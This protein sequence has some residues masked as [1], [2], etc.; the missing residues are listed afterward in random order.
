MRVRRRF[1]FG[2]VIAA[3]LAATASG[4]TISTWNGG[5]GNWST[6]ADWTPPVVPNNSGSN[7]YDVT[8]G[9]GFVGLDVS[10]TVNSLTLGASGE[11]YGVGPTVNTIH[12]VND[13]NVNGL[14][15]FGGQ[16]FPPVSPA[17]LSVGGNLNNNSPGPFIVNGALTVGGNLTNAGFMTIV[18]NTGSDPFQVGGTFTNQ[19]GKSIFLG[20]ERCF[21]VNASCAFAGPPTALL[22]GPTTTLGTLVNNGNVYSW[23]NI[24]ASNLTNNGLASFIGGAAN[25][26]TIVNAGTIYISNSASSIALEQTAALRVGTGT[27][28]TLGYTQFADGVL[29]EVLLGSS[30]YGSIVAGPWGIPPVGALQGYPIN[31]NGTL[32]IMLGNGFTPTMG[33][34]F[35]LITTAPGD[36]FGTFSNV[37]W[38]SFDNGQGG[39]VVRYDNAA[40]QVVITAEIVPEPSTW[41]LLVAG[42][43]PCAFLCRRTWRRES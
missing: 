10:P 6:A 29:D 15:F 5:A 18:S 11:L 2:G 33:E 38:D 7:A 31:L 14:L 40:G 42:A 8:V 22:P 39:W 27:A 36:I 12:V 13:I 24:T 19:S 37:I 23:S 25:A 3:L 17:S 26:K 1:L 4:D 9:P 43:V 28:N 34:S 41:L 16:V 21:A 30:T 35:T 32:D 20:N